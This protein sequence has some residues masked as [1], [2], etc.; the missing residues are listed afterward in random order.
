[1]DSRVPIVGKDAFLF[2]KDGVSEALRWRRAVDIEGVFLADRLVPAAEQEAGVVDV[3][4]EV[5][6]SEEQVVDAGR[7]QTGFD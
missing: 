1:M 2:V 6:V 7:P 3:V 4:V 5:V